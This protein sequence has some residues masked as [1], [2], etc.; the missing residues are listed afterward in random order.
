MLK[1][2]LR[3]VCFWMM[4]DRHLERTYKATMVQLRGKRTATGQTPGL[5]ASSAQ[6]QQ[7][8]PAPPGPPEAP[9]AVGPRRG[10]GGPRRA[11]LE[12]VAGRVGSRAPWGRPRRGGLRWAVAVLRSH[13]SARKLLFRALFDSAR[14]SQSR[15]LLDYAGQPPGRHWLGPSTCAVYLCRALEVDSRPTRAHFPPV[16]RWRR[17]WRNQR[18][19]GRSDLSAGCPAAQ[20][21]HARCWTLCFHSSHIEPI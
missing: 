5:R 9:W 2:V 14:L 4:V 11:S 8:R 1:F 12:H 10:T 19:S 6:G 7:S 3:V 15:V 13:G 16:D 18:A 20:R 21:P 17:R